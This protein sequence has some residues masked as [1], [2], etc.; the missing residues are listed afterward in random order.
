M[1]AK[2]T[3]GGVDKDTWYISYK[4]PSGINTQVL[5]NK[6]NYPRA[7]T[8]EQKM[9]EG[10]PSSIKYNATGASNAKQYAKYL[11]K[12]NLGSPTA[13]AER[14]KKAQLKKAG[15][16]GPK[17]QVAKKVVAKKTVT[18]RPKKK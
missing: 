11:Q 8:K 2:P 18:P 3:S 1:K 15:S 7:T 5:G 10:K 16:E 17:K 6:R 12:N 13:A 14:A 9:Y 4:T